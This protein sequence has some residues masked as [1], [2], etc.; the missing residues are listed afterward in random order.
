MRVDYAD[1]AFSVKGLGCWVDLLRGVTYCGCNTLFNDDGDN[2]P[3][4]EFGFFP[5]PVEMP[6]ADHRRTN[7]RVAQPEA[8]RTMG[9]VQDSIIKF[10]SID[11]FLN[12]VDLKCRNMTVWTLL[13]KDI[14]WEKE[15]ELRLETLWELEGF[16]D[17]PKDL[18]P[19]YPLLNTEDCDVV[20]FALG[21]YRE[22]RSKWKFI[23]TCAHY[24]LA[25][26]MGNN[27]IQTSI[28]L[29]D[30]FGSPDIPDFIYCD[31]GRCIHVVG[32]DL[33]IMMME[34]MKQLSL[35]CLDPFDYDEGEAAKMMREKPLIFQ[36]TLK[37]KMKQYFSYSSLVSATI[38]GSTN[39]IS[40]P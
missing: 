5:L 17:L 37:Q 29:A 28:C 16:S 27:T 23:P 1:M 9:V 20:Y 30:C 12:H 4:L 21:E 38:F 40:P 34:T 26:N 32:L 14:G 8:Y 19:M 31:F 15:Y 7:T 18:T 25:V 39:P 6:G 36:D 3:M 11:G 33:Y 10:V 13:D 22:N 2:G 24:L 35:T